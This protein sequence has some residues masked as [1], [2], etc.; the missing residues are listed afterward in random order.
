MMG[1]RRPRKSTRG[2]GN[3]RHGPGGAQRKNPLAISWE[4]A[5]FLV[6]MHPRTLKLH[7]K[8]TD[9]ACLVRIGKHYRVDR[10]GFYRWCRQMGFEGA[11][12]L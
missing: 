9:A 6:S 3:G 8:R 2:T 11:S 7:L 10:K 1:R 4:E 5:A 12:S